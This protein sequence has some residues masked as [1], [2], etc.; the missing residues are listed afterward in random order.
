MMGHKTPYKAIAAFVVLLILFRFIF[1][2]SLLILLHLVYTYDTMMICRNLMD[3]SLA[4][5]L[6]QYRLCDDAM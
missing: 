2:I 1:F 4:P 3:F 6:P 5:R